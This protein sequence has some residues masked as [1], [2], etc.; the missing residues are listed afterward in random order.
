[1]KY[2]IDNNKKTDKRPLI[3]MDR[4]RV[5]EDKRHFKFVKVSGKC[6]GIYK[7]IYIYKR[8]KG[9]FQY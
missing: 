6:T 4:E 8:I 5:D 7:H 1:M 3:Y 2:T 9:P